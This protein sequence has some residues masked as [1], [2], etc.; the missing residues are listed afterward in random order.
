MKNKQIPKELKAPIM[1]A[2]MFFPML[3]DVEIK[4]V[5]VKDIRTSIMQAQ[6][7]FGSL[8]LGKKRRK[9]VI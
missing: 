3:K 6:P 9:Y 8:L 1:E 7:V 2:L 5:L 4:F